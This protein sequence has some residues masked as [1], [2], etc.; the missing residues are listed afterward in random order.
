[1]PQTATSIKGHTVR[2]KW[3]EGPTAGK[4]YDHTF[5]ADGS[6]VF[7]EVKDGVPQG[8]ASRAK[9]SGTFALSSDVEIVSY[10]SD[11]KMYGFASNE[12]QLW[13]VSGTF[14]IVK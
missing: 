14:E 4:V 11:H 13:P 9:Q 5:G 7:R 1:M 8:D 10:L 12:K 2:W 3:T 6:V